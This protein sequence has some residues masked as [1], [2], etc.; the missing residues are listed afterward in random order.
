MDIIYANKCGACKYFKQRG[1]L[2][3]GTCLKN[4]CVFTGVAM[5]KPKCRL[6]CERVSDI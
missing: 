2:R 3:K 6:Y 5:S 4:R 1:N